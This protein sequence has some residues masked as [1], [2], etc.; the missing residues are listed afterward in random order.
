MKSRRSQARKDKEEAK[1]EEKSHK[2]QKQKQAESSPVPE[3]KHEQIEKRGFVDDEEEVA[4]PKQEEV[5]QTKSKK[6]L[7]KEHKLSQKK[8]EFVRPEVVERKVEEPEWV[9]AKKGKNKPK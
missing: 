1:T 3:K 5:T 9:E 6:E 4:A 7:K 2:P 8:E